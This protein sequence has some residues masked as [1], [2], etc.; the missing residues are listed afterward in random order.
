M[1][2]LAIGMKVMVTTN[3]ET[4]LDIT[5][6]ARGTIMDIILHPDESYSEEGRDIVLKNIPLYLLVKLERTR[7]TP[8]KGLDEAVIP[9]ELATKSMQVQVVENDGNQPRRTVKWRQ[10][11]VTAA[12]A[13]MDY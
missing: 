13:F 3:V 11:P 9:V 8:L 2:E 10:F 12:Y 4:D 7:A 6:G 5:N 1:V